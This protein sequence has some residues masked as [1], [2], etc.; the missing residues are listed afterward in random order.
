MKFIK[1]VKA[2]EVTWDTILNDFIDSLNYLK[3]PMSEMSKE[4]IGKNSIKINEALSEISKG[5]GHLH[6]V[7][8]T[9]SVNVKHK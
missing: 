3:G 7:T 1:L 2:K 6:L 8:D 9:L 4:D 5:I